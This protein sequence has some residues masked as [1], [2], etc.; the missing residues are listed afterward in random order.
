MNPEPQSLFFESRAVGRLHCLR[1]LPEEA[2]RDP[3]RAPL[4]ALH[5]GGANAHWWDHLA[6]SLARRRPLY[7]LD[8]RGHGE[9]AYPERKQVGAFG[10]DLED[11]IGEIGRGDVDLL[12]HSLGAAVALDHASRHP[13]TRSLALVDLARGSSPGSGRRAR[14]ALS[15]HRTYPT[16]REAVE[17]FRFLPESRH[18]SE[19]LRARIAGHSVRRESDGRFGYRFDPGWFGLP[20][21]PR[22]SLALVRCPTLLVRGAESELLSRDAAIDFVAEIPDGRLVEIPDAGHHVLIDRPELLSTAID[23]FHASIASR[24]SA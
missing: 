20:S 6:P 15:L 18:A 4:V 8:F 12:G 10:D 24:D 14:L 17:R 5:G 13:E 23:A 21:R 7:A 11:L 22:P 19:T 1:W 16:R 9:S 2:D 3:A